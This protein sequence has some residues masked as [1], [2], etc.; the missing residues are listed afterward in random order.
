M[1]SRL[2]YAKAISG[3]MLQAAANVPLLMLTL[4]TATAHHAQSRE[5]SAAQS[6][7]TSPGTYRLLYSFQCVFYDGGYPFAGL[8]GDPSGNLYGTTGDGGEFGYGTV[9]KV[10]PSGTE[11]VIHDFPSYSTDG[12][13]PY[14]GSLVRDT[15]GNLYG[16]TQLGGEFGHGTIF[17]VS[18]AG[19]ES[20]RYSFTGGADGSEPVA[21]LAIDSA[22]NLYGTASGGGSYGNGVVFELTAGGTYSVLHS[23]ASSPTDGAFPASTLARDPSGNLYGTT[24]NGGASSL[25]TIFKVTPSGAESLLHSFK[26]APIDG[27][28]PYGGGLLRDASGALYGV[29][30]AGGTGLHGELYRLNPGGAETVL[31]NFKGVVGASPIDGLARDGAGNLYGTT[32]YGGTGGG[33][34]NYGCGVLFELSATGTETVL[35]EF[36]LKS[37]SDGALPLGGV[38]R[39]PSGVLYGTLSNGGAYGCGAVFQYTP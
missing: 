10:T 33:C 13:D 21:G 7:R 32:N 9:F 17:E 26:G 30:Y 22:D 23:F 24:Q 8:A 31:F 28:G 4:I 16:T 6:K 37:S 12:Y 5:Q 15:S 29:T 25:G 11:R 2:R 1:I 27:A 39:N 38:V 3:K 36:S 35:H 14:Y 20:V 18:S 19:A 34:G